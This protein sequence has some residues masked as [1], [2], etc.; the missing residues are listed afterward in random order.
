VF[1]PR[2]YLRLFAVPQALSSPCASGLSSQREHPVLAYPA[3]PRGGSPRDTVIVIE[4]MGDAFDLTMGQLS[5]VP[6]KIVRE[7]MVNRIIEAADQGVAM[8]SS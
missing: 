4:L 1:S 2:R 8:W 6:A 3:A 7:A 5:F